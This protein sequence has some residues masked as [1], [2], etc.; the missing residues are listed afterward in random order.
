MARVSKN[1]MGEVML[2]IKMTWR[3]GRGEIRY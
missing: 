2:R 3:M 1:V